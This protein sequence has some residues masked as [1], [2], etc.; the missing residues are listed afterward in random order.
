M[1]LK[2]DRRTVVDELLDELRLQANLDSAAPVVRVDG[3]VRAAGRYP[4]EPDMRVSDLLRAGGRLSES[5]FALTAEVTRYEV[6]DGQYREAALI[7]VDLAAIRA[8]D[9]SADVLLQ[10]HD[11]L[12]V[13]EVTHWREQESVTLRGEVRFPG[14]YPIR[15]DET[16]LSV[17]ARA[18]G[19]TDRAYPNGAIFTREQ[20]RE[21]EAR[22]LR[23]LSERMEADLAALALQQSQAGGR[24]AGR[25]G[26]CRWTRPA[27]RA[28]HSDAGR[29]IGDGFQPGAGRRAG[30]RR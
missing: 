4:L 27:E 28:E 11:F 23:E 8:G 16:L 7:S 2:A 24:P 30:F 25:G 18:G 26:D 6:I 14:T 1:A 12:N 10:P 22:Q 3:R 19:L 17:L 21:R 9:A 29:P 15:K 20:L 13:K 5:A